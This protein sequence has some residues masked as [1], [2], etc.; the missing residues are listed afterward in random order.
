VRAVAKLEEAEI[1]A[2]LPQA[3]LLG[4]EHAD[5]AAVDVND[6]VE[7]DDELSLTRAYQR[8]DA[9]GKFYVAVADFEAA[10]EIEERDISDMPFRNPELCR[11]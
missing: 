1:A 3:G 5:A 2:P 8:I 10:C 11:H 6:V 7:V 4:H 9:G